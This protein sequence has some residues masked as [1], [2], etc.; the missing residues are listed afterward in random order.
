MGPQGQRPA[1]HRRRRARRVRQNSV[2][3]TQS[4]AT[5]C[6]SSVL[7]TTTAPG[8]IAGYNTGYGIS[9]QGTRA[10]TRPPACPWCATRRSMPTR[11]CRW[12]ERTAVFARLAGGSPTASR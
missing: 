11:P 5:N 12:V 1:D 6:S 10:S 8:A 9:Q 3:L 4:T 7:G 2:S